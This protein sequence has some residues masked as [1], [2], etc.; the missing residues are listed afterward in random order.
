M[1]NWFFHMGIL[2]VKYM[3]LNGFYIVNDVNEV[4]I[5]WIYMVK[6]MVYGGTW[7]IFVHG[8]L[9]SNG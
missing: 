5:K 2:I 9:I 3:D 4:Y 7:L 1:H 8:E 6:L